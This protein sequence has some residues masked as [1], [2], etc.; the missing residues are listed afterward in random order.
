MNTQ[1]Y[2]ESEGIVL[3]TNINRITI[4]SN[5]YTISANQPPLGFYIDHQENYIL[6]NMNDYRD[7]IFKLTGEFKLGA[8]DEYL[9]HMN[10]VLKNNNIPQNYVV[11][12]ATKQPGSGTRTPFNYFK[13]R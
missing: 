6:F 11:Y 5:Q 13:L 8:E 4:F 10:I 3:P 2:D 7:N 12:I 1:W 9:K